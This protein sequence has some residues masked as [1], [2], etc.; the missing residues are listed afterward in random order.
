MLGAKRERE[1]CMSAVK[2]M[3]CTAV[4]EAVRHRLSH[5]VRRVRTATSP[6]LSED[7]VDHGVDL[8]VVVEFY[9][10]VEEL[11]RSGF[12]PALLKDEADAPTP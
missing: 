12:F 5:L 4:W 2:H 3:N 10:A 6:S 1:L 8:D 11:E 7:S 9:A